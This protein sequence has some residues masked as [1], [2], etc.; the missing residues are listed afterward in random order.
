MSL[1]SILRLKPEYRAYTWGGE[2]LRPGHRPTAEAWVVYEKD[3]IASGPVAGRELGE[4][5]SQY[6]FELLGQG[7]V[8]R[9][10]NRFPLLIKL[11]DCEQWLSLQVHPNDDQAR[12]IEGPDQWGKTEAWHI[13]EA[14][15]GARLISGIQTGTPVEKMQ[16]AIRNGTIL[17]WVTYADVKTGDTIFMPAGTVHA[18]GP[19]LLVYEVQ[20]T[21]DWTYRVYDWG[22]PATP[23]RPLHLEKS[24]AVANHE[25]V[26]VPLPLP[27]LKDGGRQ[28]LTRCDYFTLEIIACQSRT[29]NLDTAGQTFHALTVIQG[30]A[31]LRAGEAEARLD[32]FE[33]VLIPAATGKYRLAPLENCRVL[34][35]S[36]EAA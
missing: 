30:R 3:H 23:S 35:A 8:A 36:V 19:G 6:P 10:G 12:Q 28:V 16:A 15:P 33:T 4:L 13:L 20:E 2:R 1:P 18:L 5:A 9:T 17:D 29:V 11:L 14:A 7:V 27:R 32:R 26:S 22:R 24:L 25:A 21:S 34:L 31:L